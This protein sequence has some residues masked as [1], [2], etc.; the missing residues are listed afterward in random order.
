ME[1][2]ESD[3]TKRIIKA[4]A[5]ALFLGNEDQD[6]PFLWLLSIAIRLNI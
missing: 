1:F 5:L 3:Q 6:T 4:Q 2:I